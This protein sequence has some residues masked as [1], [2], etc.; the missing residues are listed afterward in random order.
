M[1]VVKSSVC[2]GGSVGCGLRNLGNSCYIN[3][4][5]QCLAVVDECK[6]SAGRNVDPEKFVLEYENLMK[7]LWCGKEKVVTPS[8]FKR[9]VAKMDVRFNNTNP[10]DAQEFLSFVLGH[11]KER[12]VGDGKSVE[13]KSAGQ[14]RSTMCCAA[15]PYTSPK[16]VEDNVAYLYY[17]MKML[18]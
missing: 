2:P 15:C 5:M 10:Q 1:K 18:L 11:L 16:D 7:K 9:A 17:N 4:V 12:R 13:E 6:V 14:M 8:R 3:A